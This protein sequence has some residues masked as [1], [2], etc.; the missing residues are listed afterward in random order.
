MKKLVSLLLAAVLCLSLTA[1]GGSKKQSAIDAYNNA[2]NAA[3]AVIEIM[4]TDINAYAD[5][6]DT[7]NKIISDLTEI[8]GALENDPGDDSENDPES[9]DLDEEALDQLI[10]QCQAIEQQAIELKA[11]IEGEGESKVENKG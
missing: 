5:Y 11:E 8:A 1:C 3:N 7:M 2:A 10:T 6:I 9:D 4:N